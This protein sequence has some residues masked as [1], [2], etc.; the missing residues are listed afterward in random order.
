[1][2]TKICNK[3]NT[4]KEI[5]L[6]YKEKTKK[7][8]IDFMCKDCKNKLRKI[9]YKNNRDKYI[10]ISRDYRLNNPEKL[11]E[12]NKNS[13]LKRKDKIKDYMKEYRQENKEKIKITEAI[14]KEANKDKIKERKLKYRENNR[15]K[16]RE[17][18]RN[19]IQRI[20]LNTHKIKSTKTEEERIESNKF[21][22]WK[23]KHKRRAIEKDGNVTQAQIKEL[24]SN[25]K[26]CYWCNCNINNKDRLSFHVDHYI[27]LSKGGLHSIDNLVISCPTC[28]LTKNAKDPYKFAIEKGRLF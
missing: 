19:Y 28:N 5:N 6:F 18:K 14:Y 22:K 24:I 10:E 26:K 15:D 2:T 27:P 23:Y 4:E 12:I 8:G 3:C 21:S 1:M 7:D 13:K 9:A 20:R 25:T 11:K 16:I 17:A